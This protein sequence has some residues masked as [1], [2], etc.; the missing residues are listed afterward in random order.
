MRCFSGLGGRAVL[1]TDLATLLARKHARFPMP[2]PE[3]L[4]L[5]LDLAAAVRHLHAAGWVHRDLK[6]ANCGVT[7]AGVLKVMDFGLA[8][9]LPGGERVT[10]GRPRCREP[11]GHI[12]IGRCAPQRRQEW[13]F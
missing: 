12:G 6:P 5:A 11:G 3:A 9:P 7:A 4:Q 2:T 13:S 8:R 1:G 10:L